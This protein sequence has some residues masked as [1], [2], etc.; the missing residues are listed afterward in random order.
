[1]QVVVVGEQVAGSPTFSPGPVWTGTLQGEEGEFNPGPQASHSQPSLDPGG[2]GPQGARNPSQA[3]T[4]V[5][6]A[7]STGRRRWL[8]PAGLILTCSF[9]S[10]SPK[11]EM[12]PVEV[13]RGVLGRR[14]TRF[15]R[16]QDTLGFRVRGQLWAWETR[17]RK[18]IR[19]TL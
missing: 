8:Q 16:S 3:G 11:V 15:S 4:E 17:E 10:C 6:G 19:L 9:S 1:M 18:L 2:R 7:L 13:R 5:M 12:P 14:H